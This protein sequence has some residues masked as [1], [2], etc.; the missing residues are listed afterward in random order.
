M[1][2]SVQITTKLTVRQKR[3]GGLG[4]SGVRKPLPE[5]SKDMR[6]PPGLAQAN[7]Y[8][9]CLFFHDKKALMTEYED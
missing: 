6:D 1:P 7:S 9:R 2:R 4:G 8:F 5:I 3:S